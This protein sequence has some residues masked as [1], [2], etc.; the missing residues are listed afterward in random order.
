[1]CKICREVRKL[2]PEEALKRVANAMEK[3]P[4]ESDHLSDLIDEILGSSLED[5]DEEAER[6]WESGHND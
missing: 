2:K 6:D 3:H 4:K 1:M 5:R